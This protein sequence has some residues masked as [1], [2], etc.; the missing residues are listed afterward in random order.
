MTTDNYRTTPTPLPALVSSPNTVPSLATQTD[1]AAPIIAF[2]SGSPEGVVYAPPGSIYS[3]IVGFNI[4]TKATGTGK[5]GWQVGTLNP[6]TVTLADL[7]A[8]ATHTFVANATG[9]SASPTAIS[10]A[11]VKTLLAYVTTDIVGPQAYSG[12]GSPEAVQAAAVGSTY[13]D[14]TTPAAPVLYLK[15]AGAGN[16]GWVIY[17]HG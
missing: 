15:T 10:V 12:T 16:T 1:E 6:G 4:Y 11:T 7:A 3:D 14:I 17:N 5:T 9:G 8:Q 13:V 2:G